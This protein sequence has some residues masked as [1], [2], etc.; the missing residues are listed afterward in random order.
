MEGR[1]HWQVLVRRSFIARALDRR[2]CKILLRRQDAGLILGPQDTIAPCQKA[3]SAPLRDAEF[4]LKVGRAQIRTEKRGIQEFG[5]MMGSIRKV[6]EDI[7]PSKTGAQE[8][9]EAL[10]ALS[11]LADTKV[12]LF[13]SRITNSLI[14]GG[15]DQRVPIEA[16][17][18]STAETHAYSAKDSAHIGATVSK[19]LGGFCN[20]SKEAI[21]GG[22]STLL[23][24]ALAS[25]L[26]NSQ[27][28]ESKLEKYFVMAQG[29]SIIR[30]DMVAWQRSIKAK[31]ISD[32]TQNV[33]AFVLVK[34][35]VDLKKIGFNTFLYVYRDELELAGLKKKDLEDALDDAKK[36]YDRFHTTQ[37]ALHSAASLQM[38]NGGSASDVSSVLVSD[39]PG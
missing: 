25:F 6:I 1:R 26:G 33:S 10:E 28:A 16:I 12:E 21:L 8:A 29:F 2:P 5:E 27:A 22:V 14:S 32:L 3:V 37:L 20:G 30:V 24:E 38:P 11:S 34:S 19:S 13:T 15:A 9:K 35:A 23:T 17:L 36:I 7:D 18:D 39:T 31:G 4:S